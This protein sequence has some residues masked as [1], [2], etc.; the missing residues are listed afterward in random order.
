MNNYKVFLNNQEIKVYRAN[1]LEPP[2]NQMSSMEFA[3]F[4]APN[5]CEITIIS[6]KMIKDVVIRPLSYNIHFSYT[7]HEIK[8]HLP[9]PKK[10]SVEINGSYKDNILIF[11]NALR[12]YNYSEN[13]LYFKEGINDAGII[14]ITKDNTT[15]YLEEGAIVEGKINA[16]NC[17]N[18]T[19]CGPGIIN[20]E[21]YPRNG[22]PE[23]MHA[24]L[25]DHC[26]N[27]KILDVTIVDSVKWSCKINGC[28][29]VHIDNLKIIGSRGNS[30]GIDVCGSR[31]VL[32]EN[33]FTRTWD[34]SL[35]VKAFDTGNLENV[36]FRN[37]VLWNDFARPMEVGVEIQA[38]KACNVLFDNI[39]V[40]HSL[41]GYPIMGIHHGDRAVVSDITF[42]NI[43]VEDAPGAQLFDLRITHSVWNKDDSMGRIENIKFSNIYLVGKQDILPTKS[44]I[45]GFSEESNIKNITFENINLLGKYASN[46]EECQLSI[47]DFV[48]DV[49]FK[50]PDNC[51]TINLINTSLDII[52][53]FEYCGK[54]G[55]Y[56]GVVRLTATNNTQFDEEIDA[57]LLISPVNTAI[58][59]RKNLSGTLQKGQAVFVDYE[60]MLPPGKFVFSVQSGN[61]NIE[62]TWVLKS[63][64]LKLGSDISSACAI[65][66]CNYYGEKIDG[67]RLAVKNDNLIIDSDVKELIIYTAMPVPLAPGQVM[68]TV[69]ETDFGEAPA[70]INGLH[71]PELAPQLRCP[72]EITYV[73]KNQ[74]PVKEIVINRVAGKC[75]IPFEKLGIEPGSKRFWLEIEAITEETKNRR[76]PF[77]MFHS[78]RPAE[79]AHMFAEVTCQ[80]RVSTPPSPCHACHGGEKYE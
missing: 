61:V 37:S 14:E 9:E 69:E 38:E 11:A 44:R 18:L 60:I 70:V 35:V 59:E 19:I 76:Y 5:D 33:I 28:D 7:D 39:D 31:N 15:V 22:K 25:I 27:V 50:V 24:M 36:T 41:T 20:M 58:Y 13:V 57:Y 71:G 34:D 23:F 77:T 72:A 66:F 29:N 43:R 26:T 3:N 54:C 8:I 21:K 30:D 74:P 12:E 16:S 55:K 51:E 6:Q 52:K 62:A 65:P 45:Q 10:F 53:P 67:T 40:I 75:T 56:K 2:Y 1:V 63:F 78:V 42:N 73:F 47:M 46:A 4:T 32:C 48:E 68:F 49:K 64:E 80:F 17:N 79:I